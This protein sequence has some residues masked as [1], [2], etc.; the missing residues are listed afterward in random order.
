MVSDDGIA[1]VLRSARGDLRRANQAL[2]DAANE[3]GGVDNITSVL[4]QV[5]ER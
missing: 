2:L 4:V 5:L 1:D 3:A